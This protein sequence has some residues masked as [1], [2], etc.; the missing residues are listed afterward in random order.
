[1]HDV[2]GVLQPN[3][4]PVLAT[5][6][7]FVDAVADRHA[8]A[9]PAFTAAGP[10]DLRIGWID[11]QRADRLHARLIEHR[12]EAAAAIHRLPPSPTFRDFHTPPL[13]PPAKTVSRPLS[14][15]AVTAATR[16]LIVAEPIF[17]A[18]SPEMVPASK[19]TGFGSGCWARLVPARRIWETHAI[20]IGCSK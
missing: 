16:P 13:A 17:R 6:G 12:T 2:L 7:G 19:R 10:D 20:A 8:V 1:F 5:V 18:G 4:G 14:L 15:K 9:H 3:I 11:G